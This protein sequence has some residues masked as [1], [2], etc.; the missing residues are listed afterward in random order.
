MVP[1]ASAVFHANDIKIPE[2]IEL[3]GYGD[4]AINQ[5]LTPSI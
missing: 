5:L 3:I 1:G 4:T 2:D